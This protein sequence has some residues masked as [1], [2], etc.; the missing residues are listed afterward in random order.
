MQVFSGA[1]EIKISSATFNNLTSG[2]QTNHHYGDSKHISDSYNKKNTNTYDSNNRTYNNVKRR[3]VYKSDKRKMANTANFNVNANEA[4]WGERSD[5]EGSSGRPAVNPW[6]HP[7]RSAPP[8]TQG[9][10]DYPH[11]E[12]QSAEGYLPR[13]RNTRRGGG[14]TQ[15]PPPEDEDE[16][17]DPEYEPAYA[18]DRNWENNTDKYQRQNDW[19]SNP[20]NPMY[21]PRPQRGNPEFLDPNTTRPPY[22]PDRFSQSSYRSSSASGVSSDTTARDR[23]PS[24]G[25]YQGNYSPG[26]YEST[27]RSPNRQSP[28][29]QA[30]FNHN[31][32]HHPSPSSQSG[33]PWGSSPSAQQSSKSQSKNPFNPFYKR[34]VDSASAPPSSTANSSPPPDSMVVDHDGQ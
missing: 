12:T 11:N 31:Y 34:N 25:S 13:G 16:E 32:P 33:H 18:G 29:Q 7:P 24:G 28:N 10:T 4:A 21:M 15:S 8:R 6:G 17:E 20:N 26:P 1:G 27:R 23:S 2:N 9:I 30:P 22:S 3:Q 5:E 14:Y 19:N